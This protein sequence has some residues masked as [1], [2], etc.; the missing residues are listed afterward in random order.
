MAS[1]RSLRD[2][3][4]VALLLGIPCSCSAP[5]PRIPQGLSAFDRAVS[6][7]GAPLEAG[8]QLRRRRRRPLLRAL[9]PAGPPAGGE[10]GQLAA[11]N[12]LL[13][14]RLRALMAVEEEN[15]E[16]RRSLQMRDKVP[17]DM[18]AAEISG[19]EQSPFF[20]VVKL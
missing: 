11:D 15:K 13:R 9:G 2:A 16:L 12:R 1:H 19:V 7:I 14:L 5:P 8:P 20:R 3:L 4:L 6:G 17:E 10:R 18:L